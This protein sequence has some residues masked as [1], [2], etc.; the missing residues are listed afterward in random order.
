MGN[1]D[2]HP[3][4]QRPETG[5]TRSPAAVLDDNEVSIKHDEVSLGDLRRSAWGVTL[6]RLTAHGLFFAIVATGLLIAVSRFRKVFEDFQVKLPLLTEL[7]IR[8]GDAALEFVFVLPPAL[9]AVLAADGAIL[10]WLQ[11]TGHRWLARIWFYL[12]FLL[13]FALV[14]VAVAALFMPLIE[15]MEA[16][17]K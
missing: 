17:S 9:V 10:Y 15:L 16:L 12:V 3:L 4:G 1:A 2:P 5:I 11:Y 13:V 8:I 14:A 7:L 6:A